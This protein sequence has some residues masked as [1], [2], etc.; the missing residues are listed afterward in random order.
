MISLGFP[1]S[2]EQGT[3]AGGILILTFLV[4]TF[5]T[6]VVAAYGIGTR[7]LSFVIIPAL[8]I[9]MATSTIV[10][11]NIGAGK[12]G[13]A[14]SSALIAAGLGFGVLTGAGVLT[15]V[16]ARPIAHAFITADPQVVDMAATFIRIMS[17]SFG[18]IGVQQTMNGVFRGAGKTLA[19]MV[20]AIVS[21]WVLRFPIAYV[22]G[23]HTS[24]GA[25]GIWWAFPIANVIAAII[26]VAWFW[27][28]SW[29]VGSLVEDD[30]QQ[31]RAVAETAYE[32]PYD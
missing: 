25:T 21:L 10:G 6:G 31:G 28:G 13:R 1:A 12:P 27:Q 29:M 17:F 14:R 2:I 30:R 3:R 16:F 32:E 20:L 7:V 5:G 11:Q 19:S 22:L 18:F 24:L 4:G 23:K 9:A 26:A 15:F 8:G